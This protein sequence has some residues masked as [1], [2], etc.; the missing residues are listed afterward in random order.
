[1]AQR[2]QDIDSRRWGPDVWRTLHWIAAAYPERNPSSQTRS[3]V[4]HFVTRALP[5]VLLPCGDCRQ[6]FREFLSRHRAEASRAFASRDA[7]E[8]FLLKAHNR[9]AARLQ[10]PQWTLRQ[11]RGE[12]SAQGLEEDGDS[13]DGRD[14]EDDERSTVVAGAGRA[15]RRNTR[16]FRRRRAAAPY[17]RTSTSTQRSNKP[18]K[19]C[20]N[21]SSTRRVTRSATRSVTRRRASQQQQQQ[22]QHLLGS[23]RGHTQ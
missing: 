19:T 13:D 9:V 14:D 4:E 17:T 6:H 20:K 3:I 11:L 23:V 1:M 12:F 15:L 10:Q 22:Q 5:S 7:L 2:M 21:C 18:K 16:V 8:R